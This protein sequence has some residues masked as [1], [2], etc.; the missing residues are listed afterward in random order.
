MNKGR[1]NS[2]GSQVCTAVVHRGT[3]GEGVM[4]SVMGLRSLTSDVLGHRITFPVHLSNVAI[5][6]SL[7]LGMVAAIGT[8]RNSHKL[9]KPEAQATATSRPT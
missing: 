8:G 5:T 7:H 9:G 4:G 3:G 6:W 1:V 2:S